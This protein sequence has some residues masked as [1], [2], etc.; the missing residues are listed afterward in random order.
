M[1]EGQIPPN[2]CHLQYL[3][4]IDLSRNRL[5]GSLPSCIGG[6]SFGYQVDELDLWSSV[7]DLK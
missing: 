5:L 1:F 6:M 3:N 2:L 4:V 7:Y